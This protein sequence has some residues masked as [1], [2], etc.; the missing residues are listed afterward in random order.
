MR[1]WFGVI[2][3][4]ISVS[5]SAHAAE[6]EPRASAR[7][8]PALARGEIPLPRAKPADGSW[9]PT[10]SDSSQPARELH[11]GGALSTNRRGELSLAFDRMKSER[12]PYSSAELQPAEVTSWTKEDIQEAQ[13]QCGMVLAAL[14]I[15]ADVLQPI[16]GPGGCGI[17]APVKISRFGAIEVKPPATLNCRLAAAIYKWLTDVV[18]PSARRRFGEPVV[19]MVNASAYSCRRRNAAATGRISEHSFGNAL[20]MR[21]FRLASGKE[22]S[23]LGEWSTAGAFFGI[24]KTSSFLSDIHKGACPI[25]STVMGPRA[26]AAHDNHFHVDLGRD[27]AYKFCK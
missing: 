25:F 22:I 11:I 10:A 9:L 21:S 16:G 14:N 15:E 20:D 4:M 3:T 12:D 8:G 13:T 27:G 2:A 18:Q 19:G 23:V 1:A 26:N 6:G 5:V 7:P 24:Y 17:A